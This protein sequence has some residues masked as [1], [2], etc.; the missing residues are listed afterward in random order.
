VPAVPII[1]ELID[2]WNGYYKSAAARPLWEG[3]NLPTDE[4]FRAIAEYVSDLQDPV[5]PWVIARVRGRA[6]V[7]FILHEQRELEFPRVRWRQAVFRRGNVGALPSTRVGRLGEWRMLRLGLLAYNELAH[8]NAL[9]IEHLYWSDALRP[10]AEICGTC[11]PSILEL[12]GFN[13]LTT[14]EFNGVSWSIVDDG[15][16]VWDR[17]ER[18]RILYERAVRSGRVAGGTAD[19]AKARAWRRVSRSMFGEGKFRYG[20]GSI[21]LDRNVVG[22]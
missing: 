10:V 15:D 11:G 7:S 12:I 14:L 3:R 4:E 13:P 20:A 22:L 19:V 17:N 5:A 9:R 1:S 18:D 2:A 8:P 21:F 16:R 6:G